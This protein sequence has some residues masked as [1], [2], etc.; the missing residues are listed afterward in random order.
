MMYK[1]PVDRLSHTNV[2]VTVNPNKTFDLL[3]GFDEFNAY[4]IRFANEIK[5]V[6]SL[7]G[8]DRIYSINEGR[9]GFGGTMSSI[10]ERISVDAVLE[11]G[12]RDEKLHAHIM[13]KIAHRSNISLS[14][15][16]LKSNLVW[17]MEAPGLHLDVKYMRSANDSLEDYM[18]KHDTNSVGTA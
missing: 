10:A 9:N 11:V 18:H 16:T 17:C 6:F 2:F 13:V 12:F 7:E 1:M 5:T 8:L 4:K 14:N 3:N 15:T